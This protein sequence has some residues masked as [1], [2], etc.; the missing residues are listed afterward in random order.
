MIDFIASQKHYIDHIAPVWNKLP[1]H[2][3]HNFYTTEEIA[4]YAK[5]KIPN[6]GLHLFQ[7]E[8]SLPQSDIP[9]L[10]C[11][12]GDLI[13]AEK[14]SPSRTIIYMEHGT[15]HAF[16][17]AAYPNGIGKR[18]YASLFLAPNVYTEK[19]IHSVRDT[20]VEIIGTPK[21]DVY[22][23]MFSEVQKKVELVGRPSPPVIAIAFHWGDRHSVPPES[24]SAWEHYKD[25]LPELHRKYKIIAHG[26]PL[27]QHIYKPEFERMGIEWV[28]TF[29]EV[30]LRADLYINDLSSTLYEF[31]CTG[32]PVI[33][34]NAPWFRR[35]VHW[36]IRFWD[37]SDVGI[38]VN[39]PD[40]LFLAI[41]TTITDYSSIRLIQREKM[42]ADLY[43]Y[44]GVS[45]QLAANFITGFIT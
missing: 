31:A 37:Y 28:E 18:D 12:Y 26:H 38:N 13:A 20:R 39:E 6:A 42:V 17:T 22:E 44:I 34:L 1:L 27:A 11:S 2:F 10:V 30:L 9:V 36:G 33:I 41:D 24:G 32:K 35:D 14:N 29:N 43:P 3:K 21:M 8:R 40:E 15:G 25:V 4:E 7:Y 5:S 23:G 19:L 16:G 45:A